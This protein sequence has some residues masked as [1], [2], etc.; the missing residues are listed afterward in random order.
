MAEQY[1]DPARE[2]LW[3][4]IVES[5]VPG[6]KNL[7]TTAPAYIFDGG[8]IVFYNKKDPY[9]DKEKMK[10]SQGGLTPY[11]DGWSVK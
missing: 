7:P 2:Q 11:D 9:D 6:Y 5:Y 3:D 1:R 8:R 4:K 10:G